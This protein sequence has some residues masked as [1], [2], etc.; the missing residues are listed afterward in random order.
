MFY[1]AF[2]NLVLECSNYCEHDF[3]DFRSECEIY[4]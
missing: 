4:L 1:G 2:F 3:A